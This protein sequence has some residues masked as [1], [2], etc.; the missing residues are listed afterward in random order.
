M[1]KEEG[2]GKLEEAEK[3]GG[4]LVRRGEMVGKG[5]RVEKL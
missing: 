1:L 3:A 2:E 5:K 4:M